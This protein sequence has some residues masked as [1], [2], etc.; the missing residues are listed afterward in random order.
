VIPAWCDNKPRPPIASLKLK[1]LNAAH[2]EV[3][4]EPGSQDVGGHLGEDA[5]LLV[6]QLLSL[7]VVVVAGARRRAAVIQ[8]VA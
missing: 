1:Q 7:G 4:K 6:A 3:L 2:R 8:A 5:S